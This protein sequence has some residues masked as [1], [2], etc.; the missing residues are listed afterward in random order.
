VTEG[1]EKGKLTVTQIMT[2]LNAGNIE[3][4]DLLKAKSEIRNQWLACYKG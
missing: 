4:Y 2:K 3:E 1:S